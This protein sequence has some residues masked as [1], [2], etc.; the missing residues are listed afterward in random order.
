MATGPLPRRWLLKILMH[1]RIPTLLELLIFL[2]VSR[3]PRTI[4]ST[5]DG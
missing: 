3:H 4:W 2:I 1:M 5:A